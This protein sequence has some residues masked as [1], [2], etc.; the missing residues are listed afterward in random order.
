MAASDQT[1]E[2]T[3]G[4]YILSV[5]G[6]NAPKD[7]FSVT[8]VDPADGNRVFI[9]PT[10]ITVD[11]SDN[12]LLPTLQASDL[13]V[14]GMPASAVTAVDGDTASFGVGF[15]HEYDGHYYVLTSGPM[16]WTQAESEAKSL[17]G[18]LV[19]VNSQGE[20][21]FHQKRLL[22]GPERGRVLWIGL[23]DSATKAISYGPARNASRTRIGFPAGSPTMTM[24]WRRFCR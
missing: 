21:E 20:E 14:D 3:T 5:K 6:A 24:A 22:S 1:A 11:V 7:E 17:G 13:K 8:A 18:H 9:P 23:N 10:N 4:E 2:L 16:D 12:I 19:T 15:A